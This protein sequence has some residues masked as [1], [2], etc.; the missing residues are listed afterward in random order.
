MP[1]ASYIGVERRRARVDRDGVRAPDDLAEGG[2]ERRDLGARGQ[3]VRPE[4]LGDRLDVLL[5]RSTAGR[6]A[7]RVRHRR[8]CAELDR[9]SATR[10]WCRSSS[11]SPAGPASV[12]PRPS[13]GHHRRIGGSMTNRSPASSVRRASSSLTISSCSFSPGRM[14]TTSSR[15]P[16]A[17]ACGEVHDAHARDLRARRSRPRAS[18]RASG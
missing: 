12:S 2:L 3:V 13:I 5:D 8:E 9:R 14:P 6:T 17:I 4:H 16:G 7:D 10:C 11:G 1:V 15:P 18:R